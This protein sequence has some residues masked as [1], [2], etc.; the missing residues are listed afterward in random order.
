[1]LIKNRHAGFKRIVKCLHDISQL[2]FEQSQSQRFVDN[3]A[4]SCFSNCESRQT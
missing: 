1:M 3:R 2:D 4:N